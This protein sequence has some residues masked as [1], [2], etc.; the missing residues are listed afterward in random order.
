M[1]RVTLS[2]EDLAGFNAAAKDTDVPV[3]RGRPHPSL[4]LG[5]VLRLYLPRVDRDR[6]AIALYENGVS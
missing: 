5:R 4:V 6:L 3:S 2:L 1:I